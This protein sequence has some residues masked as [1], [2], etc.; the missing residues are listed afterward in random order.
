LIASSDLLRVREDFPITRACVYLNHAA[1]SPLPLPAM[2]ALNEAARRLAELGS[3]RDRNHALLSR[4]RAQVARLLDAPPDTVAFVHGTTHGLG[5]LASG[6]DWEPGDNVVTIRG[7]HPANVLPWLNL[8]RRGVTTRFV[9]P[10]AGAVTAEA[11]LAAVD[12]RTRVVAL[13]FVEFWN[14]FRNDLDTIGRECRRQGVLLAVDAI[15]GLGALQLS[16]SRTPIDYLAA[17][18]HKWLLG[19]AGIGIA[20]VHPDLVT[21]IQPPIVGIA[22][23]DG[24]GSYFEYSSQLAPDARRLQEGTFNLLG[25]TALGA[26]LE[27]LASLDPA[28]IEER[29]VGLTRRLRAGLDAVGCTLVDPQQQQLSGIISFR[30]PNRPAAEL[31]DELWR[32]GFRLSLRADFVRAA[33]HFY[34]TETEVDALLEM[35]DAR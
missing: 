2:A 34:N 4:V 10:V 19:A 30:H 28:W 18:A 12:R 13:S 23:V 21:R 32:A 17:G 14:G 26:S 11:V 31:Q 33:P 1:V 20:Y 27:L 25:I 5:Q 7:E 9:E 22:S 3:E 16:V 35:L 6:L 29:V 15:Q 24:E 8:E